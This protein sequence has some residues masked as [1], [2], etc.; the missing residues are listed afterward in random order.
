MKRSKSPDLLALSTIS[1]QNRLSTCLTTEAAG[2][3]HR[4]YKQIAYLLTHGTASV[5]EDTFP[6]TLANTKP[7]S[8]SPPN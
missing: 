3:S 8:S 2:I 1:V 4:L 6:G 7:P 5:P